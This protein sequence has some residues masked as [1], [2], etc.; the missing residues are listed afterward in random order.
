[1]TRDSDNTQIPR[2]GFHNPV[3]LVFGVDR[4]NDLPGL[5]KGR[6]ALLVTTPGFTRRGMTDRVKGLV[7]SSLVKI[8]DT[9]EPN[10]ELDDLQETAQTLHETH[11]DVIVAVGGGSVIDTAKAVSAVLSTTRE[12]GVVLSLREHLENGGAALNGVGIPVIAVPTTAGTGS[13]ATPF[14]TVWDSVNRRKYSLTGSQLFPE[15]A[16]LDPL[17]ST[18]LPRDITIASGLDA[19]SHAFE[20]IWNRNATPMTTLYATQALRLAMP[21]L[22]RVIRDPDNVGLR[23]EML[24]ASMLAGLAISNTKTALA[25]SISYPITMHYGVPHGLACSFT[26]PAI[27]RFNAEVDDGRLQRLA[28]ALRLNSV[29]ELRVHVIRLLEELGAQEMLAVCLASVEGPE[30]LVRHML[31][32]NRSDNNL[33]LVKCTDLVDILGA[34]YTSNH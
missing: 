12:T 16:L 14:A 29:N 34:A 9:V 3:R 10:P 26:L 18:S 7:G 25:H 31:T 33:R 11:L 23:A 21:V 30:D 22:E 17:L 8:V 32:P 24:Q 2:W 13:E 15:A 5:V 28:L 20:A 1:M 19:V 6:R 27:L 4:L